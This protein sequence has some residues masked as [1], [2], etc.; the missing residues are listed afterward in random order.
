[1]VTIKKTK[2]TANL[3]DVAIFV[4]LGQVYGNHLDEHDL[5]NFS[6]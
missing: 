6:K 5:F 4:G 3:T 2:C 1:M